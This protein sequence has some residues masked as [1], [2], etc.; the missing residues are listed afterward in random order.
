MLNTRTSMSPT[1]LS[2]CS[3]NFTTSS[4]F[5]ASTP[6]DWTRPPSSTIASA[7]GLSSSFC[8][9]TMHATNPSLANR[10]ATAPPVAFP[11]PM[12]RI[13]LSL[14][15]S[16]SLKPIGV[17]VSMSGSTIS[18]SA[19]KGRAESASAPVENPYTGED[20]TPP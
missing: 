3:T 7:K 16:C 1:E 6:N 8:L 9:L 20:E 12:T 13:T 2:M 11:A 17:G 18:F 5:L 10:L 15:G 4:S 14:V 19:S